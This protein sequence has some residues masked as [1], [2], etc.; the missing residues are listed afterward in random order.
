MYDDVKV[1]G[2]EVTSVLRNVLAFR[3]QLI[4]TMY[5]LYVDEYWK[6]GWP[7][8]RV[9]STRIYHLKAIAG[10]LISYF[11]P[12]FGTTRQTQKRLHSTNSFYLGPTYSLPLF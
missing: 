8:L 9:S 12:C 6:R 1:D 11:S 4:P 5:S 7:V 3:Y 2:V 10:L